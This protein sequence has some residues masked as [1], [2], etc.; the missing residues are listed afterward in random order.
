[1]HSA[2]KTDL[3]L[4]WFLS[5]VIEK[6]P[7]TKGVLR[8]E[9]YFGGLPGSV[10]SGSANP[11]VGVTGANRGFSSAPEN[12]LPFPRTA[13]AGRFRG[14]VWGETPRL[15]AAGGGGGVCVP[16]PREP[17]LPGGRRR[18][19]P[20]RAKA[21]AAAAAPRRRGAKGSGAGSPRRRQLPGQGRAPVPPGRSS[22][23]PTGRA[24]PADPRRLPDTGRPRQAALPP[25]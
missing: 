22:S 21:S 16:P 8:A 20:P 19:R 24:A 2:A 14:G 7:L 18:S 4:L 6:I 13:S 10:R 9:G 12:C 23:R 3:S 1:M 17:L 5:K 11:P 15:P 25:R